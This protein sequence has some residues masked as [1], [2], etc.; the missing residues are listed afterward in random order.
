MCSIPLEAGADY[1]RMNEALLPKNLRKESERCRKTVDY[2]NRK[3]EGTYGRLSENET[4]KIITTVNDQYS[5]STWVRSPQFFP[6]A[7]DSSQY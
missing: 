5:T 1:R 7:G 3:L 4:F 6:I 2:R